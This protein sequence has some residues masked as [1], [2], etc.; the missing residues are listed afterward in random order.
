MRMY[1]FCLVSLL[2]LF[3]YSIY[4]QVPSWNWAKDFHTGQ[5]E[6]VTD[7]ATDPLTG[8]IIIVGY[9]EDDLSAYFPAGI[10]PS[11]D[12]S[13]KYGG[14]TDG[15]VA[16]YDNSG[17]LQWAFKVGCNQRD[18]INAVTV[19][20]LGNIYITGYFQDNT[21]EFTGTGTLTGTT[22]L[23]N[24]DNDD[25]FFLAKYNSAGQLLW[26]R[27]GNSTGGRDVAGTG[28]SAYNTG[29]IA[30]GYYNDD[31]DFG[32]LTVRDDGSF[33]QTFIVAYDANGN[34]Q[35]VAHGATNNHDNNDR[36]YF[37]A[38]ATDGANIY[39]SGSYKGPDFKL[40]DNTNTVVGSIVNSQDNKEEISLIS[41]TTGGVFNW[42]Q[43]IGGTN[44]DEDR[45]LVLY[46]DSIYL[47]GG[48]NTNASFP[49]YA[50]NPVSSSGAKDIFISSH[51]KVDGNTGWVKTVTSTNGGDQLG[52]AITIDN[53]SN[54]L[55]TGYYDGTLDF[56]GTSLASTGGEDGFIASYTNDGLFYWAKA[57]GSSGNDAGYGIASGNSDDI[58][59]GGYYE[60]QVDLD[61]IILTDDGN[62]NMFLAQIEP[63]ADAIGGTATATDAALCI[64][65][66]TTITLVGSSGSVQWQ[67]SPT[68]A[69]TWSDLVGETG[70]SVLVSPISTTDYRAVLFPI[71]CDTDTSTVQ[72]IT[73][74]PL[75]TATITGDADICEGNSTPINI[76]LTGT[77]PYDF[78]YTDGTSSTD[79]T[80][81]GT[82]NY[83]TNVSPDDTVTYTVTTVTDANGC[84]NTGTGSAAINVFPQV[85]ISSQPVSLKACPGANI[86]FSVVASGQDLT[87]QWRKDGVD[88]GGET[89]PVLL[90]NGVGAVDEA[91][92]SCVITSSC[93][94][95]L[96][97]IDAD[98][99]LY[100]I[101]SISADPVDASLCDGE[102]LNLSVTASGS[103][104][105]YQWKKDGV[106]IAGETA[107]V[108][109]IAVVTPADNGLY[110]CEVT[111]SCGVLGSNPSTVTVEAPIVITTQ[112][113]GTSAC[114]GDN[115]SF[116]VTATG[117]N[118]S[119]QWQKSGVDLPGEISQSLIINSI[120]AGDAGNYRCIIS[121]PC[122]ANATSS[123]ATLT[124]DIAASIS[125]HPTDL[126]VCEGG[127]ANFTVAAAGS[128]LSYQWYKNAI[129]LVDGGSI[130]GS[131][132][133]TLIITGTIIG[134]NGNYYCEVSD[135]CGTLNSNPAELT[136]D[137]AIVITTQPVSQSACE[138]NNVNL[139]VVATGSN[140]AYQW[141]K[142]GIAMAGEI[143]A[144]LNINSITITDEADYRCEISN[145]CG[146]TVNSNFATLTFDTQTVITFHPSDA[147]ECL[148]NN[149]NFSVTASGTDLTYQWIKDGVALVNGGD[150]SGVTSNNLTVTNLA[151]VDAGTYYCTVTGN[152]GTVNSNPA[153]LTVDDAIKI[154]SQ[155]ADVQAC[156]G[157]NISF[158][159][160]ATGSN[161]SYQWQK[162][163]V[164]IAGE[165][166]NVLNISGINAINVGAYRC[167]I[168]NSCGA[169]EISQS[170]DL[171]LY[172]NTS[173]TTQPLDV[174][175]CI[176]ANANFNITADGSN[177]IYQWKRD[178]T[179]L[180]NGGNISG[181]TSNTLNITG[182]LAGDNGIYT[183]EVTGSC[184]TI[185]SDPANL[186]LNETTSITVHPANLTVCDDGNAVFNVT[187]TGTN[188]TYQWQ[189][190]GVN[191]PGATS[192]GY[193][194]NNVIPGDAG[195][196][197]CIVSGD[198]GSVTSNG[199]LLTI[200]VDVSIIS[201]PVDD[202]VCEN[203]ISGFSI[204]ASGSG[205]NYQWRF[206]GS[207]M[208]DGG[209]IAGA[210]TPNLSINT[211]SLA[212][213]GNYSCLVTGSCSSE[214]SNTVS[215]TVNEEVTVS[216]QPT[217]KVACPTDNIV[218][219]VTA[220][221]TNLIYQWQ[222]DGI[223]MIGQ[224][225]SNLLLNNIGAADA[226]QYRCIITGTCGS[227]I[228]NAATLT[229]GDDVS[230]SAQPADEEVCEGSSTG[231]TLTASGT[232]L[233]YQWQRG[234]FNLTDGGSISGV[235]TDNLSIN[236]TI[237]AD[238]GVYACVVTGTCSTESSSPANL[239]VDENIVISTQ[240]LDQAGCSG[241]NIIFN[242]IASG[243]NLTYQW[244]KDGV[245][246]AGETNSGLLLNTIVAGDA[247]L[248]QCVVT[249]D[250]GVVVSSAATLNVFSDVNISVQ[251]VDATVC[252]GA[253]AGFVIT[254][255]GTGLTY[256]WKKNAVNLSDGGSIIGSST[257]SLSIDPAVL[258]DDGIYSCEV[259]GVCGVE[260][261]T[262]A[263]LTIDEDITITAHPT[264]VTTCETTNASF[265]VAATGTGL[266]Y[267]WQKDG[268][269]LVG[270]TS[271]GLNLAGVTAADNGI[272]RCIITGACGSLISNGASLTVEQS[273]VI[274]I[275][276]LAN[277]VL[278][279]NDNLNLSLTAFGSNL[280]Y[281]W[282]KDGVN[283][284]DGG[285]ISGVTTD[286]LIIGS[287]D[288]SDDGIY[289]CIVTGS[290]GTANSNL[291]D[292]VVYPT[293]SIVTHPVTYTI[294]DGGNA[295][296]SVLADGD[297]LTYQWQKDGVNLSDG[298]IIAGAT[299]STLALTGVAEADEGAYRCVVSGTCG[300]VNSN[301]ANLVVNPFTNITTQPT[302]I[303]RCEGLS[304][305]FTIVAGGA[306]NTYQWRKDGIDLVDNATIS[307]ATTANLN[308]SLVSLTDAGAYT[309]VVN[310]ENSAPAIL[311]VEKNT[312]ITT[313]PIAASRC[314]G[315]VA[316]FSVIASGTALSYQWQKDGVNL[317]DGGTMSGTTTDVLNISAVA[318]SDAGNYR[319]VVTGACGTDNSNPTALTVST[320][321]SITAQ[322]TGNTICEGTSHT[323]SITAEGNMLSYVWKKD[324][325]VLVDGGNISGATTANLTVATATLADAG[326][327]TCEVTG[328]C[329]T[330]N[331]IIAQLF[332]E[333][334]TQITL[335]PIDATGCDGDNISFSILSEGT[336]LGYQWQKNGVNMVDGGTI[337]GVLTPNLTILG[338]VPGDAGSY[339]CVVTGNCSS[340]N[341]DPGL[342][343]SYATTTIVTQPISDTICEGQTSTFSVVA[344]GDN[345]TYQWK[346]GGINV[347]NGGNISG[348]TTSTLNI[349]AATITDG[350][351]YSC[352][353]TGSC[354]IVISN[355]A[356]LVVRP[357]TQ[358]TSQPV[359]VD[360]CDGD[361]ISFSVVAVGHNLS[362]QWQKD[363]VNLS[364]GGTIAGSNT[365]LLTI[366]GI[367]P[368]DDGSYRCVVS[369]TCNTVNS[370]PALLNSYL[371]TSISV[372]PL[373]TNVCENSPVSMNVSAVG[374]S[375]TYQWYK[376]GAS[377]VNGA[378]ISGSTTPNL[379]ISSAGLDDDGTYTVEVSGIC[380]SEISNFAIV[381]IDSATVIFL[382]PVSATACS[383]DDVSFTINA[384][385]EGISYQWQKDGVNMADGGS[386]S[387][388][389]TSLLTLSGTVPGDDGT[390]RCVVTGSCGV[391]NSN[392]ATLSSYSNTAIITQPIA[393]TVCEG[394]QVTLNISATGDNLNYQWKKDGVN[395]FD[396]GNVSGSNNSTLIVNSSV[397]ANTGIYTCEVS[398]ECGTENS[399][400]ASVVIR[401]TTVITLQ[402]SS[403]ATCEGEIAI[404]KVNATGEGI[405]YLWQ[406]DGAPLSDGGNVFGSTT[407]IL[408]L[409]NLVAADAGTYRCVISGTCGTMNS[410]GANLQVDVYPDAAGVII[411]TTSVCQGDS[412]VVFEV[413]GIANADYYIW[414]LP[415]GAA[416]TSGDSTRLI[417]VAF[418]DNELGGNITVY[419]ENTCGAGIVSAAHNVV[420]NP[421][422]IA[423]A[424]P[425]QNICTDTTTLDA[426]HPGTATGTWSVIDGPAIINN[427]NQYNSTVSNLREGTNTFV[428]NVAQSGCSQNDTVIIRNN[429]V[430]VEAG[431]DE[432]ICSNAK[433]LEGNT[434]PAGAVG[435]WSV[436]SG[437]A[438]FT[439]GNNPTTQASGF[440]PGTNIL[441]WT[442]VN[443]SCSDY[444]SVIVDNQAPTTSFA[445]IDQSICADS[446]SLTGNT[447]TI[448]SGQ[449]T[450][451]TG[452]ATFTDA[453]N[454]NTA[455]TNSGMG[456]NIL[457]WTISNGI[458]SS[459]DE[460]TISNNIVTVNAGIDQVLCDRTTS[461]TATA[462]VAG[463]GNW[464]V[465]LGS[466]AFVNN[467]LNNTTVTGLVQGDNI[468]SWNINNNGCISSD[469]VVI[470]N[471]SPTTSDA[472]I[473]QVITDDFTNL[474]AN[475]PTVGTG[476]WTLI[477]GSAVIVNPLL[478]NTSVTDLAL[479]ENTFRWTIT[480]N[481]CIS[482]DEVIVN[483][484]TPTDTDAGSDQTLCTNETVL[485][486]NNPTFGFGEWSV[487]LGSATFD[488]VSQ[489][490]TRVTNLAPGDNILRWTVWQNGYTSDDVVITNNAST[491]SN[492]GTDQTLCVD[493]TQLSANNPLIGSGQWT[494]ISGS[495][496]FIND[497]LYNTS[498]L[499]MSKG[500]NIYK[501]TITNTTCIS[502]D[503][504]TVNNDIPTLPDAGVDQTICSNTTTLNPNTPSIGIGTWSV[505]GGSA[506]FDENNVSSLSPGINTL[507]WTISN[508]AC[509][510]FDEIVITNNTPS[511]AQAGADK[512]ICYDS[513]TLAASTPIIGSGSWTIQNGSAT[514]T[515]TNDPT[516][517]VSG[518]AQG[519]NVFRWTVSNSG[520][521]N[522]D[523]VVV[524]NSLIS[525]TVGADQA[526]CNESTILEANNPQ[527]GIGQWSVLGGSGSALFD[528]INQPD[529][530]VSN[531]DKGNN[532]LRWTIVN[533]IC[534]TYADIVI[535][536]NNP[537]EA[538]AGPDVALCMDSLKLQGNTP[539][540]GIGEWSILSGSANI[541]DLNDGSST[542]TSLNYGVNTLQWTITNNGC[543]S[544]D[545]VVVSNNS[546]VTSNAGSD[547]T[548]CADS[549][550]LY[551]N[552][553]PFGTGQWSVVSGS[554]TFLDN[555][556][557]NTKVIDLGKGQNILR[558][559]ISNGDC[560][561]SDEITI[562]N[563]SPSTAIAGGDQTI[564]GD[565]TTLFAN[566]P[567]I[568]TGTWELISGAASFAK[569]GNYNSKVSGLN[570]G[571]NTLRWSIEYQGCFSNDDIIITN[572]LPNVA[573]AG[574]DMELCGE[575]ISLL[576]NDPGTGS[577]QW[578][579]ISGSGTFDLPNSYEVTVSEL[580][581]GTNTLRWTISYAQCVTYDDIKVTNN[582]IELNAGVDQVISNSGT[583][584]A[585]NNPSTGSGEW[586][587]IGG[588]G[589]FT[590]PKNSITLVENIGAG[591]NTYRWAVDINGCVSFD[592]ISVT[593]NVLPVA[594]FVVTETEGCPPLDIFF[595]NNSL[596]DL[597]FIW[598]FGDGE[599]STD[600]TLKHT[601]SQS[602]V[603]TATLTVFGEN[604]E[605]ITKD[606]TI[607]VYD[608]PEASF[609]VVNKE[610]YIPEEEAL[611]I[612][613][614]VH[615]T[616]FLWEFGDGSTSTESDPR[617]VYDQQGFYNIT[618]HAWSENQCYDSITVS[619][620]VEVYQSGNIQF[621]NGFT[622]NSDGSTGG[623]YNENDFSNDVFFPIGDGIDEYHL[624]IFNKW[625]VLI[626]ES[627]DIDIGWDG[628]FNGRLLDEGVYVWKVTG[629]YNNGK[630][631]SK[632]GTVML[633]R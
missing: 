331:S 165:I 94:G 366:S 452:A 404:F 183:C 373:G 307:G 557:Y 609:L 411:G 495:G 501:W 109:S 616:T 213:T 258:A 438:S 287:V 623:V 134:D 42:M 413:A 73:V 473:D 1:K 26:V 375:L 110:T 21:A 162:D 387:G 345:L 573:D 160:T 300:T 95:P 19:D 130:S 31:T 209:N 507:R 394:N 189:K 377:L 597:P 295:T 164:N 481:S 200:D 113:S 613:N 443:G 570:P 322:P 272:Y 297:A 587:V 492:A 447:P 270:E 304:A 146:Q 601:Y 184:G 357:T 459:I 75:S 9:W 488:N 3:S 397:L 463:T 457:R 89:N 483:N 393:D 129:A 224:T 625:G 222:K 350:G 37:N 522:F 470:T 579:V 234:G 217:N 612:N 50:S 620:A 468:L 182:I 476:V 580:G 138:G 180:V 537:T 464:S 618:L 90:L 290:C 436:T 456:D 310:T 61:G 141:Y 159:V 534:E 426:I 487:V 257:N 466:A 421:I 13:A 352:E 565:S 512:V 308:I 628:Y 309:C 325:I 428:W 383:G 446:T 451:I 363:G 314:E 533:D 554:A 166:N 418:S 190:D 101:T 201:Q 353:V 291:S 403:I 316:T 478:Y 12:F 327:Y 96:T 172:T 449:W 482:F 539:I 396:T 454:P 317:V 329:G 156:D 590:E 384:I 531:L 604:N 293:T 493:S 198:C 46:N 617:Y 351:S 365:N 315:D 498:V 230:I 74:N 175:E 18:V 262:P 596:D 629:R 79:V 177:L 461:L 118:L 335:Q 503:I 563:N 416:I 381:E 619:S 139:T 343:T 143:T 600:V 178:G 551:A 187:A 277:P 243:T 409:T 528:D 412:N 530:R 194:I 544:S 441:R 301:P 148:G 108:F 479:G 624:E 435:S 149:I 390:Y 238:A 630:E 527:A 347:S 135:S 513:I 40:Y 572:D 131:I 420:A 7:V 128:G 275:Q 150:I 251:P 491:I 155:P 486:A 465:L 437:T 22:S 474:Q 506:I 621:P 389:S 333:E 431:T 523:E 256:Q 223:N 279:E 11:E 490:N 122:G 86:S 574:Q 207:N 254:A 206:N 567:T 202:I 152:C 607:T 450:V 480:H 92:Y 548:I 339:V 434:P 514:I 93:G 455:I 43:N 59:V 632:V 361:N 471:D 603:Y 460:T 543:I 72:V 51:A 53:Y 220:S 47:T 249:G 338:I 250:C 97:T 427:I 354:G 400:P 274:T 38:I 91:T 181:A 391:E 556:G 586:S 520:C 231:F 362:Y 41:L 103:N 58:Y 364:D 273:A 161:L 218:F 71:S 318:T 552:N 69:D 445:G 311:T 247:G 626:F 203:E 111:G 241:D 169:T 336:A 49:G 62:D 423:L 511:E 199:A 248:Y 591:L 469:S 614:S 561:S 355:L 55:I 219:S 229:V 402:P 516:A 545:Q 10:L 29:V 215:L 536:N 173:I 541:S 553:P 529:T 52:T 442:I 484:F 575:S 549:T 283:L 124:V 517:F 633:I 244:Q 125:S 571:T 28:I 406:K 448:G 405:S 504:V 216:V 117:T 372:Q 16:K 577:G 226:A 82:N 294:S 170:A 494:V 227:L 440:S 332:V 242:V 119:Y 298:G 8:E 453:T 197:R 147:I 205:L 265:S 319:C 176:G 282:Q 136:V 500:E 133:N 289:T 532:V 140:L 378:N 2:L 408:T 104:L 144:S 568:G 379:S 233:T 589:T 349:A 342:L 235:N 542:A 432:V 356:E 326:S 70:L 68:G 371:T 76:A 558:W 114:S 268:V 374:D 35:W 497:T 348:A 23:T 499:N 489:Y 369:G 63:C 85:S 286:N 266:T 87:Y 594:S 555:N 126:T 595:V 562:V 496:T 444:D 519:T 340:E 60:N 566:N 358:I 98:L 510:L 269:N 401:G 602:G 422:P 191:I 328:T 546:T 245:N 171:T 559:F 627:R 281:Q 261:S 64:G 524:D 67:S 211:V 77:A 433:T 45:D 239:V 606:T 154:V 462:P 4:S 5:N 392:V 66:S 168:T 330:E 550:D 502:E 236:P 192:S 302:D 284:T 424:G 458:C 576:S 276:P 253:S 107:N 99:I 324:G 415:V 84:S 252:E 80:N 285:T 174:T 346:K 320:N 360:G 36:S 32:A 24:A 204:V 306:G 102:A 385:G 430:T 185:N 120:A 106:D 196:F 386:I 145:S 83:A 615:S 6:V 186:T 14:N 585:A 419:G 472:G 312:A 30:I 115:I 505:I 313:Q 44:D 112:P 158:N 142:N 240:P 540:I 288:E 105:T 132:S 407:S 15:F 78:T 260:N 370:N 359:D 321:T 123:V 380:G 569:P 212:N 515:N 246:I 608:Q 592:D 323:F 581:F 221:G 195:V 299:T 622:P 17:T 467:N 280:T 232:G 271:A 137:D 535:T 54:L 337:S 560:S 367:V 228:S 429:N 509:E 163:G 508:N 151:V 157:S 100:S 382:Q 292:V 439:N 485:A 599:T 582:Q 34:E 611:F 57:I 538:F 296:F 65:E 583:L 33:I 27:Q 598:D 193:I 25:D 417:K 605:I 303:T 477:A 475:I 39:I 259:T 521:S 588:S 593:Y 81:H 20:P 210:T 399:S 547:A 305:A 344:T 278:C 564:C 208:A 127:N 88:I 264:N 267:Q 263:N 121:S 179:N 584:L 631:Y 334:T 610:V 526:I 398:G 225:N 578:S 153:I 410:D 255:S 414:N 425:D 395:L 368:V 237:L 56:S 188:L 525:A 116:T 518:L 214:G 388:S 376:D 167:V 341:S 48:I